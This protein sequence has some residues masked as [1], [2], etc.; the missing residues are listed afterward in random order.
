MNILIL[1]GGTG[2]K[3]WPYSETRHKTLMPISGKPLVIWLL[4]N[5]P[6]IEEQRIFIGVNQ[7]NYNDFIYT[8]NQTPEAHSL[9]LNKILKIVKINNNSGPASTLLELS[10]QVVESPEPC[11]VLNADC[12]VAKEDLDTLIS[13]ES[14]FTL[15]LS[16]LSPENCSDRIVFNAKNSL[17]FKYHPRNDSYQH[18]LIAFKVESSFFNLLSLGLPSVFNHLQCGMMPTDERFIEPVLAHWGEKN[19]PKQI[20]TQH[21]AVNVDYPWDFLVLNEFINERRC[22]QLTQNNLAKKATISDKAILRGFVS[23]GEGSSIGDNVIINGNVIV[24]KNSHITDGAILEG[25]IVIG[26]N[27]TIKEYCKVFSGSSIGNN[28]I[29]S[30]GAELEGIILDK[31]YLYHYSEIFGILGYAVDIAAGTAFGTLRFD[32]QKPTHNVNGRRITPSEFG[33]AIF[34][35]DFTRTG[36]NTTI[37]PGVKVGCKSVIGSNVCLDKDLASNKSLMLKQELIEKEWGA[38]KY[39]D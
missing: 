14:D 6:N 26:N 29:V 36:V 16:P 8:L 38:H 7:A 31:T 39:G 20:I 24:G 12:Y 4:N 18:E 34:M 32:D 3:T 15:L 30:H 2:S 22:R 25:D 11:L 13:E 35:G 21:R 10:Q 28:C 19:T 37:M 5:I 23:L 9:I 1:A 27:C 33:N 17:D